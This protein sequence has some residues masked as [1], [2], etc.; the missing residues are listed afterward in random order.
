LPSLPHQ[1]PAI[2]SGTDNCSRP[3]C[4]RHDFVGGYRSFSRGECSVDTLSLRVVASLVAPQNI[5]SGEVP[6]IDPAKSAGLLGPRNLDLSA[7]I[8]LTQDLQAS[9][10]QILRDVGHLVGNVVA[11][12]TPFRRSQA[13]ES[14]ALRTMTWA[15]STSRKPKISGQPRQAADRARRVP[16]IGTL[17]H[18]T[19]A[20]QDHGRSRRNIRPGE[21]GDLICVE[22]VSSAPQWGVK[23]RTCLD[24]S[25]KPVV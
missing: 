10:R 4:F 7:T 20:E 1:S 17:V 3:D 18:G 22:P 13:P 23:G 16:A 21:K 24:N 14:C 2:W 19:A 15:K 5:A 11:R 8:R 9:T 25:S 12:W 6:R